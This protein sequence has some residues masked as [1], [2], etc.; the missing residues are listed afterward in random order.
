M[1]NYRRVYVPEGTYFLT[2][3]TYQ[4]QPWFGD[5][6]YV[7]LL[8]NTTTQVKSEMPFNIIGA[9]ILPEH[10]H[11]IWSLPQGDINYSKRVGRLKVLFTKSLRGSNNLPQNVSLL[12]KIK[13]SKK[14]KAI[15]LR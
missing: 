15:A 10:I 12:A 1:S 2:I 6:N 3:I 11:F 5:R 4:R 14:F 8:R 13:K 7:D 9:V